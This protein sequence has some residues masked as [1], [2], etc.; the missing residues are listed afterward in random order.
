M[1]YPKNHFQ[2]EFAENVL[3]MS[4]SVSLQH[5]PPCFHMSSHN[6]DNHHIQ[7]NT[8]PLITPG[9]V[10]RFGL[11]GHP[12][13]EGGFRSVCISPMPGDNNCAL[14]PAKIYIL[15]DPRAAKEFKKM[16]ERICAKKK[17]LKPKNN[18]IGTML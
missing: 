14:L 6:V 12:K 18:N 10:G 2:M 3:S 15:M 4:L 13:E 1:T 5:A 17:Q 7:N 16:Q 9:R 8:P 11:L